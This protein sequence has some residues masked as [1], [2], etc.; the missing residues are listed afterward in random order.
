VL[1]HPDVPG[2]VD[3]PWGWYD[4]VKDRGAGVAKIVGKHD[5]MIEDLERVWPLM[6]SVPRTVADSRIQLKYGPY[7][8]VVEQA[9]D[10]RSQTWLLTTF[11]KGAG[12]RR[13]KAAKRANRLGAGT[14]ASDAVEGQAQRPQA[15]R[16]PDQPVADNI[17]QGGATS[18][19]ARTWNYVKRG[20]DDLIEKRRDPVTGRPPNDQ[21]TRA[22]QNARLQLRSELDRINPAYGRARAAYAGPAAQKQAMQQGRRA[23]TSRADPDMVERGVESLSADERAA[24]RVGAARGLSDQFRGANPQGVARRLTRDQVL[25]DRLRAGFPDDESFGRFLSDVQSEA[26]AQTEINKVL[27]GSRTTPLREDIDAANLAGE[28]GDIASRLVD[29]EA[30]RLSGQSLKRQATEAGLRSAFSKLRVPALNDPEVSRILGQALFEGKGVQEALQAA[31]AQRV[32]SPETAL[33]LVPGLSQ[34]AAAMRARSA[35]ANRTGA[36]R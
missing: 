11:D 10:G 28:G 32:L 14:V 31:I 30:R 27:G 13:L 9:R 20:L 6:K 5:E 17:S 19:T 36:P 12:A 35:K 33:R 21:M 23:V 26:A 18:Y 29:V 16:S 2:A 24:Y 34:Q 25:Q 8:A 4:P 3:L 22:L 1:A 7:T 15:P